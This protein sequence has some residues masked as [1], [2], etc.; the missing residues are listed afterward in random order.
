MLKQQKTVTLPKKD[1]SLF[2]KKMKNIGQH[3]KEIRHERGETLHQVAINTD[4]D[5]PLL[6]KIERGN[7]LPTIPQIKRISSYFNIPERKFMAILI[8][9]KI[10]SEFGISS[11]THDAIKYVE[12][13][14]ISQK[15]E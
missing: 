6:S 5:S 2:Y 15:Q 9:E 12:K 3:I 13:E 8:A 1:K 4:I 11:T 10:I 14:I 7:R